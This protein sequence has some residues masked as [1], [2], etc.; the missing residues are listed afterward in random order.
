MS[1]KILIVGGVALGPKAASRA[2]RLDPTAEVTLID[3]DSIISYGGCGIPYFVCGDVAEPEGL[4]STSFHSLRDADYFA[5]EKGFAVRTS[6]RAVKI[7]R[8]KKEL[9]VKDLLS[10]RDEVLPYDKLV[11][12]TGSTPFAPPIPGVDADGIFTVSDIHKAVAIKNRLSH[13][14]VGRAVV[15]GGGAIGLEMAEAM[16][17][18]W[19]VETT[20]VEMMDQI[21]PRLLDKNIALMAQHH[22]EEKGVTVYI[23]ERAESF[24]VENGKVTGVKTDKRTIEA[25]LVILAVGVRPNSQ[26][27]R[28]AGLAI[29][30][31]GGIVVNRR[32]QTS[33]PS[34]YAGGDCVEMPDLVS[35][36]STYAPM[37]SLANR[38]GRV[39]GSNLAGKAET[40]DG[41]VGSFIIKLF[42]NC[43][44]KTGLSL[45]S[46]KALGLDALAAFVVQ[47]DKAHFYPDSGM[48]YMQ[49]V[50]EKGTQRVLGVQGI[51]PN[52]SSLL[53]RTGAV[54]GILKYRPTVQ[55]IANLEFPYSPPYAAAMDIIN[56]LANTA[57]NI[58][59]G[60]NRA[61][62]QD[63]FMERF[64]NRAANNTLFVDVRAAAQG[65]PL[66]E[67]YYPHWLNIPN[68]QLRQRLDELPA[69]R[70]IVLVCN[71]GSR[72]YDAMCMLQNS[73]KNTLNL[74]GGIGGLKRAGIIL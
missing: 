16:T 46:A 29:G 17:D 9:L 8:Q 4:R 56:V 61:I 63:E 44:A 51:G 30:N 67:K 20:V 48:L 35:G 54:A 74:Q 37:G 22:L 31:F 71:A 6:T 24:C 11:L 57:Q 55:D 14:R 52:S 72:S 49:M 73:N 36:S 42:D 13:G 68:N 40:F 50:V 59:E 65:E 66:M 23:A 10:G 43:V 34:I 3:Q 32:M 27:A 12:A 19:G 58:L 28:E 47:S 2:K 45:E 70:E 5:S 25:D 62:N 26:L 7:D 41:V 38:Q 53:A 1:Q 33:D 15:L 69:D 64:N 21:L 39:I 18:L 60:R